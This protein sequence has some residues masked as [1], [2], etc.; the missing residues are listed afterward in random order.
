MRKTVLIGSVIAALRPRLLD[1]VSIFTLVDAVSQR[2][3]FR[4]APNAP[5][6]QAGP[7]DFH[8]GKIERDG[9]TIVIEQLL[10]SYVDIRATSVGATTKTSTDDAAFFLADLLGFVHSLFSIDITR[11]YNDYFH[12]ILEVVFDNDI[13]FPE[14]ET[15]GQTITSLIRGYNMTFPEYRLTGLNLHTDPTLQT[16]PTGLPFSLER[17]A[18]A[19]FFGN[20]VL[21]ASTAKN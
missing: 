12:S 4:N 10:V 8:Y 7:A 14:F 9:R 19:A 13:F 15:L 11:T 5:Q 18:G 3:Q 1:S 2:Y 20:E 6:L 16:I 17:R 21:F